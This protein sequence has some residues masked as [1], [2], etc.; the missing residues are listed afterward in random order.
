MLDVN[1]GVP[2]AGVRVSRGNTKFDALS[3]YPKGGQLLMAKAPVQ[4]GPDGRFTLAGERVLSVVRGSGWNEVRLTFARPAYETLRTNV[5][6]NV[7]TNAENGAPL[8]NLGPVLLQPA[9][10]PPLPM[11]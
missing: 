11:Q 9:H 6:M 10:C 7:A 1:T 3:G 8:L 5:S 4:T 2:V